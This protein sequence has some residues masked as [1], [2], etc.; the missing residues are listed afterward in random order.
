METLRLICADFDA[1]PM[2][3]STVSGRREGFDPD[4][5]ALVARHLGRSIEWIRTT[6][7]EMVPTLLGGRGDAVWCWLTATDERAL[8]VDF[9]AP[10]AYFDDAILV[11]ADSP[12][13]EPRDLKGRIVGAVASGNSSRVARDLGATVVPFYGV[14]DHISQMVAALRAGKVQAVVDDDAAWLP[15]QREADLRV[16]FRVPTRQPCAAAVSKKRPDLRDEISRGISAAIAN[17]SLATAW[18]AW[19]PQLSCPFDRSAA[20][21]ST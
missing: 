21:R 4:A 14:G 9:T 11:R 20:G 17:G 7:A 12:I 2:F 6:W 13:R 8:V 3:R 18:A 1:P 15:L 5:A 10:Y 19:L 16:A